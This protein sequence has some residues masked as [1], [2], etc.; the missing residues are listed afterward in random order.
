[1][2]YIS[3]GYFCSVASDLEKLGLRECS[4]PFDWLISDFEGVMLAIQE[5]CVDFLEY[6]YLSQDQKR[7]HVYKNTKYNIKF[8]HDFSKYKSLQEQLPNIR[9]KYNRR[10]ERFFDAITTPTCFIRYVSDE[11]TIDGKSSEL[12]YIEN[13]YD[14]ILDIIKV[15][16]K[17]NE[18]IFIANE[19]VTSDKV[20][21]FN[22]QKDENDVVARRPIYKSSVLFE[23]FSNI[24]M[25]NKQANI[26]RYLEKEKAR[27]S[28]S[29][30]LK[31][32]CVSAFNRIFLK[33]YLHESQYYESSY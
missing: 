15:F 24:D 12:V 4:S 32:K 33:E 2:H 29:S 26:D 13:N 28:M 19:G 9:K 16:N 17:E 14:K 1:M 8:C 7:H 18:I 20:P 23:K 6:R 3:L 25:P 21:L 27:N 10:I 30:Y 22:V 31:R 11:K 5:H